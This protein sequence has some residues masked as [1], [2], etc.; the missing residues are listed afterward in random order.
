[1][2][3]TS[4]LYLLSF[5]FC[6]RLFSQPPSSESLIE[7]YK[8]KIEKHLDK[9]KALSGYYSFDDEGIYMYGSLTDKKNNRPEF[10]IFWN[11]L[12]AAKALFYLKSNKEIEHILSLKKDKPFSAEQIN[13]WANDFS[14]MPVKRKSLQG[15]RIAIDPGHIAG[16]M[17]TAKLEKK[18]ISMKANPAFGLKQDVQIIEGELTLATA[19]LLKQKLE[20]EGA[21]VMLTRDSSDISAFGKTFENWLINDFKNSV[22]KSFTESA[23]TEAEKT[24]LLAKAAKRDI[25][26]NYFSALDI[27]ERANKINAFRPDIA[28]VVHY[29]VD[30]KNTGWVKPSD[31]NYNMV[32]IGGSFMKDE[33]NTFQSRVH[34]LRMLI[35]DDVSKSVDLSEKLIKKFHDNLQV[36]SA[37]SGNADYLRKNCM[38]TEIQGVYHR[39]LTLTQLVHGTTAYCET[40]YQDNI[41]EC[42]LL[43]EKTTSVR[44]KEVADAYY[45]GIKEYFLNR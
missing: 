38:D 5:L 2:R 35:T 25:F 12:Q 19:K 13:D 7:H 36:S 27:R 1:M 45:K 3:S 32:F 22:E 43:D 21:L 16:D 15:I 34:F 26:R 42:I 17:A 28:V 41:K 8:V 40:L 14:E 24:F 6:T 18:F 4:Y 23:I 39:N 29:N 37:L 10:K 30:E 31:K 33:L 20:A 44:I 11:E 9:E